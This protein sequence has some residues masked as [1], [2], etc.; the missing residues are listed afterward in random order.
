MRSRPSVYGCHGLLPLLIFGALAVACGEKKET[1]VPAESAARPATEKLV[2]EKQDKA[3]SQAISPN[4]T[5]L[6]TWEVVEATGRYAETNTG[7]VYTFLPNGTA[8]TRAIHKGKIPGG[9]LIPGVKAGEPIENEWSWTRVSPNKIEMTHRESPL[10]AQI[11]TTID[12]NTMKFEWNKGGSIFI[13]ER[14]D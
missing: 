11:T 13:M 7:L 9:R 1:T 4:D 10:V 3:E 6:G 5:L 12:G 2:V 8:Q 14:R